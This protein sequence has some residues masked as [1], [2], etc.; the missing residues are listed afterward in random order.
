MSAVVGLA[1]MGGAAEAVETD[2]IGIGVDPDDV[3]AADF[4]KAEAMRDIARKVEMQFAAVSF[5]EEPGVA[6]IL[7]EEAVAK[8]AIDLIGLLGDAWTNCG[9]DAVAPSANIFHCQNGDVGDSGKGAAPAGVGG[10]DH[11]R[12][13]VSEQDWGTICGEDT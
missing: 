13:G 6:C 9:N 5:G 12:F 3:D 10:T 2:R 1:A 8:G 7:V 11:A 4:R